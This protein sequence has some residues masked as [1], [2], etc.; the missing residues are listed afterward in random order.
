[1]EK[2]KETLVLYGLGLGS[3]VLSSI[4]FFYALAPYNIR[5]LLYGLVFPGPIFSTILY[6]YLK[7]S[8]ALSRSKNL[9]SESFK[10]LAFVVAGSFI[11]VIALF[12]ALSGPYYDFPLI[13][14]SLF[15]ALALIGLL[16]SFSIQA[17]NKQIFLWALIVGVAGYLIFRS[18]PLSTSAGLLS[19]D[20]EKTHLVAV[21]SIIIF[22]QTLMFP[23]FARYKKDSPMLNNT[24]KEVFLNN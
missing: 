11:Y 7:H 18:T 9:I 22:W 8:H 20:L 23:W 15:G 17:H 19:P 5:L 4:L 2:Y 1:M 6:V 16:R 3:G 13:L 24:D 21:F 14:G 10:M 12:L